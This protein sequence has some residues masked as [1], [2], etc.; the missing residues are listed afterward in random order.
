MA[1]PAPS[2]S[3]STG[4]GMTARLNFSD[5]PLDIVLADY[6]EK[7]GKTLLRAPGL[8]T[9]TFT[10]RSQGALSIEEYLKAI[11]TVLTMHGVGLVEFGESF[12]RVVPIKSVRR[13]GLEI[14]ET[15]P[16][17]IVAERSGTMVSQMVPLKHIDLAE[18]VK[19]ID[20]M[21]NENGQINQFE[22]TNSLMITDMAENIN[23]MLQVLR[24]IDQPVEAKEEPNI[25]QIRYAKASEIKSRLEEIIAESQK[26]QEKQSTVPRTR[27]TGA[28][29]V[30]QTAPR[31]II[32]PTTRTTPTTESAS[33][34]EAEL[35]AAAERGIIQ[36]KVQI[37][38]DERTNQLII[39]TRPSN[40]AFFERIIAVLDVETS[41][42]VI[43][44]VR[45]LDFATAEDVAGMLNDLIGATQKDEGG[46][47][48]TRGN[49]N[50]TTESRRLAEI[51][52]ALRSRQN[53]SQP[54]R[55]SSVGELSKDNI[56]ILSDKRTNS[57][58]LMASKA[59][60]VTLEEIIVDMDMMLSQ[61]LIE[62][63]IIEVSLDDA[64]ETGVS[65]VQK[66][67]TS[68]SRNAAGVRT[69]IF[70]FAGGGGSG[71]TPLDATALTDPDSLATGGLGYYFTLFDLNMN[72]L[73][74]ASSSDSRSRVV[75]TPALLT[76][77]NTEAKLT[78]TERIYVFEGT[79]YVG[80]STD[81]RT[82]RYR[83]EDV[84]L[85]LTVKPQINEDQV[86]MME[87]KQEYQPSRETSPEPTRRT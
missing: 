9:P 14:L 33:E 29:G 71:T 37:V 41:P 46:T 74:K 44:K 48:V 70:S 18:A 87:I 59:D 51:E 35:V 82:A 2:P 1:P 79:T 42:D 23:R 67:M 40:M 81:N 20:P 24:L 86:V 50:S 4:D 53:A 66:S 7:T 83:Q 3:D 78:S 8:P 61:V 22:R 6:S 43:V 17:G 10:L 45:R 11:E 25:I 60:M 75:S 84:G 15:M 68:Y 47:P 80:T 26:E 38:A 30:V 55:K 19:A 76:T 64:V 85:T 58:I 21:R 16:E 69:P 62:A 31:G 52:A 56:K 12:V 77:D 5:A 49:D 36:G 63:V 65:W 32:R 54:D 28:P 34:S 72:L 73:L 39:I 13:E 57:L 27:K